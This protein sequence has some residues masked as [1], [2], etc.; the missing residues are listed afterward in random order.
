MHAVRKHILE[1]LKEQHNGATVAELA[2]LLEMA[3][4]S[5]R[6]HLDIL[7]GDNLICVERLERKG[8]VG[9]PQQ[10]YALTEEANSYFPNNFAALAG[11]L[12]EQIKQMLP[13]DK[14]PCAFRSIAQEMAAEFFEEKWQDRN[15]DS[16]QSATFE[17]K[18]EE[19]TAFL[20]ERGY[21]ARWEAVTTKDKPDAVQLVYYLHKY[22]C[23][24]AGVSAEHSELCMMDQTLMNELTGC[25]CERME[26]LANGASCC[27]YRLVAKPSTDSSESTR[28]H[29]PQAILLN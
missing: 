6:H 14:V 19:I 13:P 27:T 9:R 2:E 3:P 1:I 5:V 18:L 28:N 8:N 4:V 17:Q 24:Y 15:G 11:R 12:V 10:V 16:S 20:T 7:Q 25:E 26:S 21:L 23:P 29:L 22:N